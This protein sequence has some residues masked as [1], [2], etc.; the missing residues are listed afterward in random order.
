LIQDETLAFIEENKDQP[1]FLFYALV[2]P[3]A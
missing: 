3:H 2:Q 1:F